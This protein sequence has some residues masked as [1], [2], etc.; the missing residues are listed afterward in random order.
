MLL[1]KKTLL[2]SGERFLNECCYYLQAVF[3][4]WSHCRSHVAVIWIFWVEK[5]L[6]RNF[7]LPVLIKK[8]ALFPQLTSR[9]QS[10]HGLGPFVHVSTYE[11]NFPVLLHSAH[12]PLASFKLRQSVFRQQGFIS[13]G[14]F[15]SLHSL[16]VQTDFSI[17]LAHAPTCFP[18]VKHRVCRA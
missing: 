16:T 11:R 13:A 4:C 8:N 5:C 6:K 10:S 18:Q 7:N 1:G 3:G 15:P 12:S 9:C 2:E 17:L 14:P